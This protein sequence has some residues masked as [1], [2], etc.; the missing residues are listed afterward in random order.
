MRTPTRRTMV[1]IFMA[2]AL[3]AAPPAR[4]AG[5]LS[6]PFEGIWARIS[7]LWAETGCIYDPNG[8]C[9]DHAGPVDGITADAG[10]T[11]DPHG[12]CREDAQA[13]ASGLEQARRP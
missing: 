5:W 9:R 8:G 11:Y 1:P 12:G 6:S 10:C 13:Q 3:L 2:V 4:A 7:A